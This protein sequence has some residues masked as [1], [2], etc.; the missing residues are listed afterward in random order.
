MVDDGYLIGYEDTNGDFVEVGRFNN[1]AEDTNQPVEIVHTGSGEKVE[2]GPGGFDA[3]NITANS[4]NTSEGSIT[5]VAAGMFLS[6]D[7]TAAS[8]SVER[9][10]YDTTL[11]EDSAV[12][13]V[14]LSNDEIII[15]KAGT[16]LITVL[17]TWEGSTDWADGDLIQTRIRTSSG[18]LDRNN[19]LHPG[20]S[21]RYSMA[22]TAVYKASQGDAIFARVFQNSGSDQELV[23]NQVDSNIEVARIG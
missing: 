13:S 15:E 12:L 6:T 17:T 16:Y 19:R 21:G 20:I 8:G 10:S 22:N 18:D 11:F 14:D 9:I 5:N 4:V 23:G 3:N 1:Q 2:L 7:Q